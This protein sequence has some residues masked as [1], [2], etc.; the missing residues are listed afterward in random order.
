[1]RTVAT[2]KAMHLCANPSEKAWYNLASSQINWLPTFPKGTRNRLGFQWMTSSYVRETVV[3]KELSSRGPHEK[4]G[5]DNS[6]GSGKGKV[7]WGS[8]WHSL[9]S[10]W[11]SSSFKFSYMGSWLGFLSS[12][13]QLEDK[14]DDR[15]SGIGSAAG[16]RSGLGLAV[17]WLTVLSSVSLAW[18]CGFEFEF[19]FTHTPSL[20]GRQVVQGLWDFAQVHPA[21]LLHLQQGILVPTHMYVHW[22]MSQQP[23]QAE[24]AS[25]K[26]VARLSHYVQQALVW[27]LLLC[28][29]A[30]FR[31]NS[32]FIHWKQVKSP[33]STWTKE[34]AGDITLKTQHWLSAAIE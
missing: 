11:C 6:A 18:G 10:L 14:W 21:H 34:K 29:S 32:F 7:I 19:E 28:E 12:G 4:E 1:M 9:W 20:Q 8:L 30:A 13:S 24:R 27:L 26:S 33:K 25:F 3:M 15:E 31:T 22:R 16:C 2:F 23:Q 17:G 5:G